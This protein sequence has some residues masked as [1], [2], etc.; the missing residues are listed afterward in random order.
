MQI[1]ERQHLCDLRGLSGPRRQD[2]AS[3]AHLLPGCRI[4]PPI[5]DPRCSHLEQTGPCGD[6]PWL[7]FS[8]ASDQAT[9]L[10]VELV[11]ETGHIGLDFSF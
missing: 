11:N 1:H 7:G 3:K 8:I 10:L 6:R 4:D 9:T 2:H 5:V